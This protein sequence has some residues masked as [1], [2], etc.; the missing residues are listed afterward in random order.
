MNKTVKTESAE[1]EKLKNNLSVMDKYIWVVTGL[2]AGLLIG[3]K[4]FNI[5]DNP[6]FGYFA[7]FLFLCDIG[8]VACYVVN[9][10]AY[11]RK[12]IK[13]IKHIRND[14]KRMK[15]EIKNAKCTE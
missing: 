12:T 8:M 7:F 13:E 2:L 6:Y 3:D 5:F 4:W 9:S 11:Q 14:I 1:I 10:I 15:E